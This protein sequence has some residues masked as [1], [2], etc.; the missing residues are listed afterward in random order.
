[1]CQQEAVSPGGQEDAGEREKDQELLTKSLTT[2][3]EPRIAGKNWRVKNADFK[4]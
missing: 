4:D 2:A 1:M 3:E